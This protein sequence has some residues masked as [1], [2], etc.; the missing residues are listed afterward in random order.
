MRAGACLVF[1]GPSASGPGGAPLGGFC[2]R[3]RS[4]DGFCLHI[5]DTDTAYRYSYP[6]YSL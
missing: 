2:D 5:I 3:F 1:W 6:Y 4:R